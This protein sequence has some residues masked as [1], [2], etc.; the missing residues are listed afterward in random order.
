MKTSKAIFSLYKK[1]TVSFPNFMFITQNTF[2]LFSYKLTIKEN[3]T[4]TNPSPKS[5]SEMY[6]IQPSKLNKPDL[7]QFIDTSKITSNNYSFNQKKLSKEPAKLSPIS[8][9]MKANI[10]KDLKMKSPIE[11]SK[12]YKNLFIDEKKYP[13]PRKLKGLQ[14]RLYKSEE[15]QKAAKLVYKE[16]NNKRSIENKKSGDVYSP[17]YTPVSPR[18]GPFPVE[19][20]DPIEEKNYH[21]CSCGMSKKQPFCDRSHKSTGFKPVNFQLA[22]KDSVIYLCGCKLSSRAPFCDGSTCVQMAKEEDKAIKAKLD[23]LCNNKEASAEASTEETKE[24]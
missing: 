14:E 20:K 5:L 6:N 23:I 1:K 4:T 9:L 11:V 16:L 21:W 22:E 2:K 8:Q 15:F 7:S 10:F 24:E 12:L 3:P 13:K 19:V 18:L 17:Q